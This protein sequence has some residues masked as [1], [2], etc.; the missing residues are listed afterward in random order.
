MSPLFTTPLFVF[1]VCVALH[2]CACTLFP[3]IGLVDSPNKYGLKRK[4]IPYPTGSIASIVFLCFLLF[5]QEWNQKIIGICSSIAILLF[6]TVIDDRRPLSPLLRLA[7]HICIGV[8]LFLTGTVIYTLTNPLEFL[9]QIP[10]IRLDLLDI[11]LPYFGTL[12]LFSGIFTILWITFTINALN[13]FD[14]IPG[15]VSTLATIGFLT[16]GFLSLS[17]RVN[18]PQLALLAF[19]LTGISIACLLFDFPPP[20]VLMGDTGAMFFGLML[21]ILTIFSGGKVA[22]AFLVLGVPLIDC[23]LVAFKRIV[24]GKHPFQGS[25]TG[26]HLHHLLLEK[27]WSPRQII[28]LTALLGTGFGS[29]ALFLATLEKFA[30]ALL[31][32]GIM[33]FLSAYARNHRSPVDVSQRNA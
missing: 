4:P 24:G 23:I 8:L 3:R 33:L 13:W 17:T 9:S 25:Q 2:V 1:L 18:Q 28:A 22:T 30:A 29:S 27:G 5:T 12:P 7:I 14:G 21:G 32:I 16:I 31:F 19:T 15:Q 20:R 10:Y 26:E 11:T 6:V